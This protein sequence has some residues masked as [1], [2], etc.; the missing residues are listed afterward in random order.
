M[1]A[2]EGLRAHFEAVRREVLDE[3]G[4]GDAEAVSRRLIN[5]LLHEPSTELRAIAAEDGNARAQET[6]SLLDRLFGIG[7]GAGAS[8]SAAKVKKG[9]EE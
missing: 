1:P 2:I 3:A 8:K 5:R 7:R 6:A 9:R 4:G